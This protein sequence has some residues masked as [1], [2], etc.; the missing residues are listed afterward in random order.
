MRLH[1]HCQSVLSWTLADRPFVHRPYDLVLS[2]LSAPLH[3]SNWPHPPRLI[4]LEA[5]QSF[6]IWLWIRS[7]ALD[8]TESL[9]TL[10]L[11]TVV[12]AAVMGLLMVVTVERGRLIGVMLA[13]GL[14]VMVVEVVDLMEGVR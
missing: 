2:A 12:L 3:D 4:R 9:V 5:C 7:L 10:E 1:F 11:L 13:V 14:L 8:G 6:A